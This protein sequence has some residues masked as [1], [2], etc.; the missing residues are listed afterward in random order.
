M[1][2]LEA[3]VPLK[4]DPLLRSSSATR[5]E[6]SPFL[7]RS[8]SRFSRFL[9]VKKLDYLQWICTVVVFLFFVILFQMF[10]PGS[11]VE[12]SGA[13]LN[14]N[15]L[16]SGNLEY[17]EEKFGL[18][19]GEDIKFE[20]LKLMKKFQKEEDH[21]FGHNMTVKR[22]GYRKPRLAIVSIQFVMHFIDCGSNS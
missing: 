8:R 20:P 18:P 6:K 22:F 7:Q 16:S 4:R 14:N 10:L 1:G 15:E 19:F 9:L 3:G 2:S 5:S 11:V 13:Y 21:S 12:K 17:M